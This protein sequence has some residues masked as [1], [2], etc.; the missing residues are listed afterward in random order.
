M[1]ACLLI[2][3]LLQTHIEDL[4]CSRHCAKEIVMTNMSFLPSRVSQFSEG[5]SHRNKQLQYNMKTTI[6]EACPKYGSSLE[7]DT[8]NYKGGVELE[9][10]QWRDDLLGS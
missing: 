6:V 5:G 4:P 8:V 10:S 7:Q 9:A 3:S 1:L 2:H